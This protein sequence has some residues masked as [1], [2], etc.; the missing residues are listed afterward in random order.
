LLRHS[1]ER[2]RKLTA[3]ML[4]RFPGVRRWEETD[5]VLQG[6]LIRVDQML[7]RVEVPAVRDYLRLTAANL[8]HL[9]IDLTRHYFGPQGLGANHATP[10]PATPGTAK[11]AGAGEPAAPPSDDALSLADWSA[12]HEQ[13]AHLPDDEREVFDL[14]WYH[15]LTQLEA[16][17]VLDVSLS[18]VKRRWQSARLLLMEQLGVGPRERAAKKSARA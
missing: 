15:G 9:L 14:M 7:S 3:R 17:A 11:P 4:A 10:P 2:I 18:T 8:R 5:D 6:L 13:A 12:F 16:A 1:R